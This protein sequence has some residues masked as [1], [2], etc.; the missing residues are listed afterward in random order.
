MNSFKGLLLIVKRL[1]AI[2]TTIVV[3]DRLLLN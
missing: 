1:I 3:R 2:V